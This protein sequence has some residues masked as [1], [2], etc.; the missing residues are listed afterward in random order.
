[1]ARSS[2]SESSSPTHGAFLVNEHICYAPTTRCLSSYTLSLKGAF[3]L[4]S[5]LAD[6]PLITVSDFW[7]NY[8]LLRKRGRRQLRGYWWAG[9]PFSNT[10][11]EGQSSSLNAGGGAGAESSGG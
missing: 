6:F 10:G 8:A 3:R 9:T 2:S 5:T 4:L 11:S 1:M 7:V